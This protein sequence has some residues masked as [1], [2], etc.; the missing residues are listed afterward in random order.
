MKPIIYLSPRGAQ[1]TKALFESNLYET[2]KKEAREILD[3]QRHRSIHRRA[4]EIEREYIEKFGCDFLSHLCLM[5]AARES[6]DRRDDK[7][8]P[9]ELYYLELVRTGLKELEE[10]P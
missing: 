4:E 1:L 6:Y 8:Q 10:M 3:L 9:W 7:S 5:L 2:A